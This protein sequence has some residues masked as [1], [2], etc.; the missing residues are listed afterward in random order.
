MSKLLPVTYSDVVRA[1]AAIRGS[2]IET[3]F[4][5]S[6]TLSKLLDA[7]FMLLGS[8][9]PSALDDAQAKA[10]GLVAVDDVDGRPFQHVRGPV[11]DHATGSASSPP[12]LGGDSCAVL[13][14]LGYDDGRVAELVAQGV[15]VDGSR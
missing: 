8:D 2:V 3:R 12:L 5:Q 1:A 11:L 9:L 7:D 14:E 6:R 4:E 13:R 15:V 10:R